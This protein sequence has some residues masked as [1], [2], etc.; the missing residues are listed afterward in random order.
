MTRPSSLVP[1]IR[2]DHCSGSMSADSGGLAGVHVGVLLGQVDEIL[3]ADL[4]EQ[5]RF[6][7]EFGDR[8][9]QR[10]LALV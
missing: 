1:E 8:L 9:V 6:L 4:G 2:F 5:L 3:R 10:L 7:A